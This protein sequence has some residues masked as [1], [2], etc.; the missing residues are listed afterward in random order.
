MNNLFELKQ[1]GHN[2]KTYHHRNFLPPIPVVFPQKRKYR[3]CEPTRTIHLSSE[4][5]HQLM[6][7]KQSRDVSL[8]SRRSAL[9][10][11]LL[12]WTALV[13]LPSLYVVGRYLVPPLRNLARVSSVIASKVNEIPRNAAKIVKLG[14]RPI[15]VVH[16]EGGE[17]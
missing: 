16:T 4:P 7:A 12:G 8:E 2:F 10:R 13:V 14:T 3:S 9:T 17:Y 15:V 5:P 11:L 1:P 6:L